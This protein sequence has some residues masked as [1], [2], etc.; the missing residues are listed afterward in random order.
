ARNG[1]EWCSDV[2]PSALEMLAN[3]IRSA[4]A[5][6]LSRTMRPLWSVPLMAWLVVGLGSC[7]GPDYRPVVDMPGHTAT[8]Y[9]RDL[10]ILPVSGARRTTDMRPWTRESAR[11]A[12]LRAAPC[13][14]QSA[15][16]P[17]SVRASAHWPGWSAWAGIKRHRP[18]IARNGSS[19]TACTRT[20]S[21][22]SADQ[23]L[24]VSR[25]AYARGP[26]RGP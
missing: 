22:F 2:D 12:G 17:G 14:V 15:A 4:V 20:A 7:A 19:R 8:Q 1:R 5:S 25:H 10:A 13:S 21:T 24:T 26:G 16:T 18:K 11:S 9:N 23:A 3:C 6:S